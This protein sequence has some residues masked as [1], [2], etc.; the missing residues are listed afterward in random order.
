[1]L[2]RDILGTSLKIILQTFFIFFLANLGFLVGKVAEVVI[3]VDGVVFMILGEVEPMGDSVHARASVKESKGYPPQKN[4]RLRFPPFKKGTLWQNIP[5][6]WKILGQ[7]SPQNKRI[8][9]LKLVKFS[10]SPP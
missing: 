1:M 8:P 2:F 9:P 3:V 4:F 10:D 6:L 5:P 7:S